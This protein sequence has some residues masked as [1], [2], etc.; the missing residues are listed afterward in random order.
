MNVAVTSVENTTQPLIQAEGILKRFGRRPVL[1]NVDL[2][3][4]PGEVVTVIGPNGSGKTTLLKVLLGL[5][6]PDAGVIHRQFGLRIGY[7]PQKMQIS[8]VFPMTVQHFLRLFREQKGQVTAIA[9]ELE[10]INLLHRQVYALSGGELQRVL[11]AQALL[12][13]PHLLVLDEPVQGVDFTGQ[14]RIYQ[15]VKRVSRSRGCAV[16]MVSHDLHLVMSGT[17][18][19]VCLDRHVC[20]SGTPQS[21]SRDPEFVNM[22]GPEV[23]GQVALYVHHHDHQHNLTG[24]VVREHAGHHHHHGAD[25]GHDH[26]HDHAHDGNHTHSHEHSHDHM[27]LEGNEGEFWSPDEDEEAHYRDVLKDKGSGDAG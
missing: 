19:V 15:L 9:E 17:D 5:E 1:L 27:P 26:S 11:L 18:K 13:N 22:F 16:L 25:C 7:V 24:E 23:A 2:S 10:I 21:V 3:V 20:C 6:K 12:T 4:H 8:P 14:A